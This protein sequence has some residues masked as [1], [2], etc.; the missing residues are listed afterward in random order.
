MTILYDRVD[1]ST[2][3]NGVYRCDLNAGKKK[4]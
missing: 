3:T 1:G 4:K 2:V